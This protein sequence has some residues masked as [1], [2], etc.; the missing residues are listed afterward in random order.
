MELTGL[1]LLVALILWWLGSMRAREAA[2][3]AGKRSCA[4]AGVQFLDD[5]LELRRLGLRRNDWGQ[6]AFYREYRFEFSDTGDNRRGGVVAMLG[7]RIQAVELDAGAAN[8]KSI[9]GA[10]LRIPAGSGDNRGSHAEQT[11]DE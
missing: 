6:L 5:T 10:G 9:A 7:A 3:T 11:I 8:P 4:A 1:A 2:L